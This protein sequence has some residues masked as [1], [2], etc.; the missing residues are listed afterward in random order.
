MSNWNNMSSFPNNMGHRVGMRDRQKDG[1]EGD[2][3]ETRVARKRKNKKK[4]TESSAHLPE[5]MMG[6]LVVCEPDET[7]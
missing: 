2:E 4:K 7:F 1:R 6:L 5:G 3:G